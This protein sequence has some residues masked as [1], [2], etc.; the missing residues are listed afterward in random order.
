MVSFLFFRVFHS[1]AFSALSAV[2]SVLNTNN[3]LIQIQNLI[4]DELWNRC[5]SR[6]PLSSYVNFFDQ[7]SFS[8]SFSLTFS[9]STQPIDV[10]ESSNNICSPSSLPQPVGATGSSNDICSSTIS[11]QPAGA[12]GF[13]K[14]ICSSLLSSDICSSSSLPQL[15]GAT[16]F[17]KIICSPIR[18]LDTACKLL[19]SH[20]NMSF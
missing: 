9:I 3:F 4:Y 14:I 17:S 19:E 20:T 11:L 13:S 10:T 16:G 18:L 7:I 5:T 6:C 2:Y 15:V 12:T 8:F 1:S